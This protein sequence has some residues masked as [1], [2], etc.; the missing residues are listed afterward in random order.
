VPA[1]SPPTA[2][3]GGEYRI[4]TGLPASGAMQG[5]SELES[6]GLADVAEESDSECGSSSQVNS[7]ERRR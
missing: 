5:E 6:G 4:L 7:P 2:G 1:W 3:L